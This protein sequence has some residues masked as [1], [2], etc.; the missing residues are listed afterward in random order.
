MSQPDILS[1]VHTDRSFV[2][3]ITQ[4][5]T[6]AMDK[7]GLNIHVN[8]VTSIEDDFKTGERVLH[9][10]KQGEMFFGIGRNISQDRWDDIFNKKR[11]D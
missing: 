1:T 3:H 2:T 7:Q 9:V 8:E 10:E 5:T 6:H 11:K 4:E